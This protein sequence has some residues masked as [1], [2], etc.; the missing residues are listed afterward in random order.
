MNIA[1]KLLRSLLDLEN[2][3][4]E[5][6]VRWAHGWSEA[7]WQA[8][9]RSSHSEAADMYHHLRR[10]RS[11][12]CAPRPPAR[13]F[14]DI[15]S[16][17]AL[18][19]ERM[20]TLM[21]FEGEVTPPPTWLAGITGPDGEVQY[22]G[23]SILGGETGVGKALAIDTP[24]PTPAGWTPMGDLRVGDEIFDETGARYSVT[25]A[26]EVMTHRDCF[27]LVFSDGGRIVCDADHQ[28]VTSTRRQR[29]RR[30]PASTVTA[31][32]ISETLRNREHT[33]HAIRVAGPLDC[34]PADLPIAPYTLGVWLGDGRSADMGLSISDTEIIKEVEADG[35]KVH[36]WADKY[37]YGVQG[38][39]PKLREAGLMFNK[40]IPAI[41][42]R[43]SF[44]QRLALLQGLMDT[45]GHAL[46][47]GTNLEMLL[48]NQALSD[49]FLELLHSLGIKSTQRIGRA[50]IYGKDYGPKY[51]MSFLT[52]L[53]AFR[54]PRKLERQKRNH[55]RGTHLQRYVLEC[56]PVAS[57]PVR[58]IEVDS[59]S[60]LY[61]AGRDMIPTHNSKLATRAGLLACANP[62]TTVIY[63]CAELDEATQA[64]YATQCTGLEP[65]EV[66]KRYPNFRPILVPAGCTFER[67][68]EA[69]LRQI[70]EDC[71]RLII[72][73]DTINT[74]VEKCQRDTHDYF[75]LLRQFGIWMLESRI[76]SAGKI[77]WLAVS[78]LNRDQNVLGLK[79]DKWADIVMRF[80]RGELPR[81][82]HIDITKGRYSGA[83]ELGTYYLDWQH[84]DMEQG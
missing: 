44:D 15:L 45:D 78:E 17:T 51:R 2:D 35:F 31:R 34:P 73:A 26:T 16:D 79:L 3:D 41:Y 27:E 30:E 72:V 28:W 21:E 59:P 60:R 70:P 6:A 65:R 7:E 14:I 18:M 38:L 61:L 32:G 48:T 8:L 77:A 9:M 4:P 76:Q 11:M 82:V 83:G 39:N 56:N 29:I 47:N 10:L 81:Q 66:R 55:F 64:L 80:R 37:G 25:A 22:R 43:A 71:A 46:K 36:K 84:C 62:S 23:L 75:R 49:G 69:T 20:P 67:V 33:N 50:T 5:E 12:D 42:L 74:L 57:V 53:Q 24:I 40:H 13:D 63:L 19:A 58:C 1:A 54:V 52:D 68:V